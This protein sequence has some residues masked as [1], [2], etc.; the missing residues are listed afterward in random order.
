MKNV[1]LLCMSTVKKDIK[2]A[3]YSFEYA[4]GNADYVDG[5]MTNEA[6]T[7]AVVKQLEK[8]GNGQRLDRVVMICSDS[9]HQ[10]IEVVANESPIE[11]PESL[12]HIEFYKTMI[13]RFAEET[14]SRYK[15]QP[16][17]YIEVSIPDFTEA[18]QVSE[19]VIDAANKV[20]TLEDDVQLHL[21]FNGGQRYVAFMLVAIGNLMK[22][23]NVEIKQV[24][25]MNFE[26]QTRSGEEKIVQ[27]QNMAPVFRS[28]DLISGINEYINYGRTKGLKTYFAATTNREIHHVLNAMEQF[29]NNLQLC[30]TGY[31]MRE[32]GNLLQLLEEYS[33]KERTETTLDAYEQL[34]LYVVKDILDGYR[35]ILDGDLPGIIKWCVERDFIQQ[36]LTF[37]VEE[38][39]DYFWREKIFAAS[40]NEKKE[41]NYFLEKLQTKE[42]NK[43]NRIQSDYRTGLT[44]DSSKYAYNWMIKYIAFS[45]EQPDYKNILKDATEDYV[46]LAFE[47]PDKAKMK[48]IGENL[49]EFREFDM[50]QVHLNG[51][52]LDRAI[53]GTAKLVYCRQGKRVTSMHTKVGTFSEIMMIYFLLKEQRNVTNHA[54]GGNP[55]GNEWS[56]DELCCVLKQLA[57]KLVEL[58]K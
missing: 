58:K 7:K 53:R 16:I 18:Q 5:Y 36:A 57:V 56:C 9:V 22:N 11:H 23:R 2:K 31:I 49:K 39:P 52:Q 8:L 51:S 10:K 55:N 34:F 43:F 37:C 19:A 6:P 47:K 54:S 27:I 28:F 38:M 35:G 40:N 12:S 1:L 24:M 15:E 44:E 17:E 20:I 46:Q 21:D 13:N 25:T 29:A 48:A 32:K 45:D 3:K 33:Q 4:D 41:Y 26:T 50:S 30:R 42:A 14:N